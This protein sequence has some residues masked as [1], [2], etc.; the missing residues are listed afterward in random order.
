MQGS[1]YEY[2]ALVVWYSA[3]RCDLSPEIIPC[4]WVIML[5]KRHTSETGSAQ[6][7]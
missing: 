7:W 2:E 5:V 1:F 6:L 4:G 3:R